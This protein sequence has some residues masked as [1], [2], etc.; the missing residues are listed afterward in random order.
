MAY[1]P[2]LLTSVVLYVTLLDSLSVPLLSSSSF[3]KSDLVSISFLLPDSKSGSFKA[4][5]RVQKPGFGGE[6][7][8]FLSL[9]KYIIRICMLEAAPSVFLR[10][11]PAEKKIGGWV[12]GGKRR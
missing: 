4:T 5:L 10:M 12:V 11:L 3:F 7:S 1:D 9:P 2:T 8:G 6:G